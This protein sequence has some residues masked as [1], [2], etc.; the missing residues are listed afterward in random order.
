MSRSDLFSDRSAVESPRGKFLVCQPVK[1]LAFR[2][3]RT[4]GYEKLY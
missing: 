2:R 1:V 3:S 4:G